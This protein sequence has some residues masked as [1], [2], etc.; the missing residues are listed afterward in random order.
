MRRLTTVVSILGLVLGHN[1]ALRA[2]SGFEGVIQFKSH[3]EDE[4][5]RTM[6]Q[7]SKGS[8]I[9]FEQHGGESDGETSVA[10]FDL[11]SRSMLVLL[12]TQH[13]YMSMDLRAQAKA[14]KKDTAAHPTDRNAVKF[15]RTGR[16]ETVA[17]VP[18][19]IYHAT[20]TEDGE[21]MEG[22]ACLAKGV[23][24]AMFEVAS[25]LKDDEQSQDPVMGMFEEFVRQDLHVIKMTELKGGKP[26]VTLE[27]IKIERKPLDPSL[28]AP[29][30]G[31]TEMKTPTMEQ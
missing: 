21:P 8:K 27:A 5:E 2:Q 3:F 24:F 19:E 10:I 14:A 22:D 16:T 4:G 9:R 31:F 28:F 7:M 1:A 6:V 13:A 23:G 26:T 15:N 25:A 30:A 20:G 11:T 18:C 29:P 12:P 17:G